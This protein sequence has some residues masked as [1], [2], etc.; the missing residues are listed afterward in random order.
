M[1][2]SPSL[3][4]T[5]GPTTLACDVPLSFVAVHPPHPD[6]QPKDEGM[7]LRVWMRKLGE[8]KALNKGHW[9]RS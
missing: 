8:P 3:I 4:L 9:T 1:D 7:G 6:A 2:A 5:H